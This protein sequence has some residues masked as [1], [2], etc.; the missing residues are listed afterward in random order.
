MTRGV[1]AATAS[2]TRRGLARIDRGSLV[3]L[4]DQLR[5]ILVGR[6]NSDWR[7]GDKLPSESELC[8]YYRVSR[9]VVRQALDELARE[10]LIH[11]VKGKGSYVSGTRLDATFVQRAAGF[12]EEMVRAG[13]L[14]TSTTLEQKLEPASVRVA[15][16]L[17]LSVD[18][19]VVK[20]D[21]LRSVDGELI[22]VVRT[23][24]PSRLFPGLETLDVTDRSLYTTLEQHYGFR[25]YGGRRSIRAI[26]ASPSDA[27]LLQIRKGAP[28]LLVESLTWGNDEV[29]FEYFV[30]SYRGDCAQFDIDLVTP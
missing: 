14:L 13:H 17:G 2:S 26:P 7:A 18:E 19:P 11:K 28:I 22:Q 29:S 5:D 1:G 24:L 20:L 3:P 12:H 4:Y 15:S 9:T 16:Q 6:L 8:D 27:K 10:G 21:R 30:A 25:P 23:F